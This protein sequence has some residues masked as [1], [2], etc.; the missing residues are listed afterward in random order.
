MAELVV[1]ERLEPVIDWHRARLLPAA[2]AVVDDPRTRLH[3]GD[4]FAMTAAGELPGASSTGSPYDAVLLDIDHTPS[5]LLAGSHADFYSPDGL[6]RLTG[7]M[8]RTG[9]FG[10]WSDDPP[11]PGFTAIMGEVFVDVRAEVVEFPN[12]LTG[13]TS[14]NTVYLGTRA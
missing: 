9:V 5:H 13:G 2:P 3:A 14:A 6:R 4:F 10:L 11:D 1:V 8:T 7:Q 12:P